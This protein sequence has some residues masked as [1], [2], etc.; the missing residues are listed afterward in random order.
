MSDQSVNRKAD[1]EPTKESCNVKLT[2]I[3][4]AFIKA[5]SVCKQGAESA[6]QAGYAPDSAHVTASKLLSNPNIQALINR[7][8]D[9]DFDTWCREVKN[10]IHDE[11]TWQAKFKGLELY[12]KARGWLRENVVNNNILALGSEDLC[13]IRNSLKSHFGLSDIQPVQAIEQSSQVI[14]S[15]AVTGN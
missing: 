3:Q 8:M 2:T 5:Y 14:D 7:A 10:I 11:P 9:Y 12:G 1:K 4:L 13:R 6:R 15:T